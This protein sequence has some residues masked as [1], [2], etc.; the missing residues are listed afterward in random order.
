[1]LSGMLEQTHN[2]D[3]VQFCN[4]Q[5]LEVGNTAAFWGTGISNFVPMRCL[6]K[7]ELVQMDQSNPSWQLHQ[8]F[9]R[10]HL[11]W[12]ILFE[13]SAHQ[14]DRFFFACASMQGQSWS[15]LSAFSGKRVQTCVSFFLG[16]LAYDVLGKVQVLRHLPETGS[17]SRSSDFV[18]C[19]FF[20]SRLPFAAYFHLFGHSAP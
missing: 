7:V 10:T 11:L 6:V 15:R 16:K 17:A 5:H 8:D 3:V 13:G 19:V 14:T 9:C 2:H 4:H 18:Y 12:R 1:M 20:G